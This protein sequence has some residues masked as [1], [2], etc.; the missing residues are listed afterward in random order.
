MPRRL[1]PAVT[2]PYQVSGKR[3]AWSYR[4]SGRCPALSS[5]G[6]PWRSSASIHSAR[7]WC[8]CST[9]TGSD[10]PGHGHWRHRG[11]SGQTSREGDLCGWNNR[12]FGRRG[13]RVR[14]TSQ[15]GNYRPPPAGKGGF[16]K[17]LW[18]PISNYSVES[19]PASLCKVLTT[20]LLPRD[21]LVCSTRWA[22]LH[23]Y[24]GPVKALHKPPGR[25]QVAQS[26]RV[27]DRL[28]ERAPEYVPGVLHR[29]KVMLLSFGK[30]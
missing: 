21:L 26:D 16:E 1:A 19:S 25:C 12:D 20:V 4:C 27:L 28:P 23:N 7:S 10:R 24:P 2:I 3:R 5:A 11:R 14:E 18:A 30:G 9:C 8:A 15:R 17:E 22:L 29:H 13:E 6:G